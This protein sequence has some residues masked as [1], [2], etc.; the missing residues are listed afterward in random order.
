ME[1]AWL[2]IFGMLVGGPDVSD[3]ETAVS[4]FVAC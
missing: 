2:G 3:V 4:A 1:N